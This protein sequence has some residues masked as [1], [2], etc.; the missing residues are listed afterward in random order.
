MLPRTAHIWIAEWAHGTFDGPSLLSLLSPDEIK[1]AACLQ[2]PL[3]KQRFIFS[4]SFLRKILSRYT[5]LAP[6]QLVFDYGAHGK[7][8]LQNTIHDLRFNIS[9]SADI[10]LF[11]IT[12]EQDIG[13]DIQKIKSYFREDIVKRFF[14]PQEQ[15]QLMALTESA[16]ASA[17][18]QIWSMKEALIKTIGQGLL[19]TP[20]ADFSI[21]LSSLKEA[22]LLGC[23]QFYVEKIA[24]P[25]GYQ[26][27][28][29]TE[30]ILEKVV[31]QSLP[32]NASS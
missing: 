8:Y 18:Y 16:R 5:G 27:A 6:E 31:M 3:H 21:N 17:F 11:A 32:M 14:S 9:H 23:S 28:V 10:T 12:I 29:C 22:V 19:T 2:S 13:V 30:D 7:P 20:L 24:V 26:A 15:A 1:R 25:D 4:R